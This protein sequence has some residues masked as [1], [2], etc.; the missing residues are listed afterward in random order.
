MKKVR[1]WVLLASFLSIFLLSCEIGLGAAVDTTAPVISISNPPVDAV[2]RDAFAFSGSYSDDGT[3]IAASITLSGVNVSGSYT[4]GGSLSG[5]T[6]SCTID[7]VAQSIPDGTYEASVM[8]MDYGGHTSTSSRSFTI[9][10]T[11]PIVF[12]QRPGSRTTADESEIDTYGQDFTI[13]G[14]VADD[15]SISQMCVSVYDDAAATNL[16]KTITIA[17]VPQS[18]NISAAKFG[19]SSYTTIYGDTVGDKLKRY[20]KIVCYDD[21][22]RYPIGSSQ[23]SEDKLGNAKSYFYLRDEVATSVLANFKV[24]DIYHMYSGTQTKDSNVMSILNDDSKKVSVGMFYLNPKNNPYFDVTGWT[25]YTSDTIKA[26]ISSENAKLVC[27]TNVIVEVKQGSDGIPLVNAPNLLTLWVS[28][29]DENGVELNS[30]DRKIIKSPNVTLSKSGTNYR[31][32][33]LFDSYC[34]FGQKYIVGVTGKDENGNEIASFGKIYGFTF[35]SS[36]AA[37]EVDI[38]APSDAIYYLKKETDLTVKGTIKVE[39]NTTVTVRIYTTDGTNPI[40]EDITYTPGLETPSGSNFETFALNTTIPYSKF[41]ANSQTPLRIMATGSGSTTVS[42]TIVYDT[43]GPN[44]TL[45]VT[46]AA[47]TY[48][49]N[50]DESNY[51]SVINSKY[52]NGII[53]LKGQIVD[54]F[55][56]V[57]TSAGYKPKYTI[58]Q[59]G[60]EKLSGTIDNPNSFNISIDTTSLT[61]DT[62][63]IIKIE[64]Y[65]RCLNKSVTTDA[66]YTYHV[67][68]STDKPVMF[69][70]DDWKLSYIT[71]TI[72]SEKIADAVNHNTTKYNVYMGGA[73]LSTRIYDDD[74]ISKVKVSIYSD[75]AEKNLAVATDNGVEKTVS[76]TP[77]D[78]IYIT[79]LPTVLGAYKVVYT[80]TDKNS[81]SITKRFW[82][83]IRGTAP[84][85]QLSAT[86]SSV[87][88]VAKNTADYTTTTAKNSFTVTLDMTGSTGP[89]TI[90]RGTTQLVTGHTEATYTDTFTPAANS[91]SSSVNYKVVDMFGGETTKVFSYVVDKT[92][93]TVEITA[94]PDA[95]SSENDTVTIVGTGTDGTGSGIAS[96]QVKFTDESSSLNSGNIDFSGTTSWNYPL[97]FANSLVFYNSGNLEGIKK[98]YVRAI[99]VNGNIGEWTSKEFTFDKSK[100]SISL[101]KYTPE[102]G[103]ATDVANGGEFNIGKKFT[104]S[105]TA[106]DTYGVA[107][108]SVKQTKDDGTP[109]ALTDNFG[110][111]LSVAN[112][113]R[114]PSSIAS[115]L[116]ETGT[117]KYDITVTDKAGK[118]TTTSVTTHIDITP[119]VLKITAPASLALADNSGINSLSGSSYTFAGTATDVGLGIQSVQYVFTE[120]EALSGSETWTTKSVNGNWNFSQTLV[121]GITDVT[122]NTLHEGK[123]YLHA[124]AVDKAN[125][126]SPVVTAGFYA[127]QSVPS[128]VQTGLNDSGIKYFNANVALSIT[129]TDTFGID[130]S[131]VT[132]KIGN[133]GITLARTSGTNVWTGTIAKSTLTKNTSYVVTITAKDKAGRTTEK[134]YNV[135]YDTAKPV[136]TIISPAASESVSTFPKQISGTSSDAGS[137]VRRAYY[138]LAATPSDDFTDGSW[139]EL[140][141]NGDSWIAKLLNTDPEAGD[142]TSSKI[143]EEGT[144][145]LTVSALDNLSNPKADYAQTTF[146][147]DTSNPTLSVNNPGTLT[148]AAFSITGTA[149][150][151]NNISKIEIKEG[152]NVI[153]STESLIDITAGTIADAKS[154]A[155]KFSWSKTFMVGAGKN[156]EDGEHTYTVI[157]TDV[158]GKTTERTVNITVD[159]TP[160]VVSSDIKVPTTTETESASFTFS[161]TTSDATS[162]V[163]S[164]EIAFSDP[165]ANPAPTFYTANGKDNWTYLAYFANIAGFDTEGVKNVYVRA[166]DSAGNVSTWVNKAYTYDKAAPTVTITKYNNTTIVDGK[167]QTKATFSLTGT[168]ADGYALAD[169]NN[170]VI[171]QKKDDGTPITLD[172]SSNYTFTS[173]TWTISGLPRK[174]AKDALTSS[175]NDAAWTGSYTYTVTAKDKVD[176]TNAATVVS[177]IDK[178]A[179]ETI[180]ISSPSTDVTAENSLFG[181]S[182]IFKGNASDSGTGVK[183]IH[184]IFSKS[185]TAPTDGYTTLTAGNGETWSISRDLTVGHTYDSATQLDEGNWCLYVKAE[186]YAGNISET[187]KRAFSV[188]QSNPVFS[189]TDTSAIIKKEAFTLSGIATDTN[190]LTKVTISNGK[191]GTDAKSWSSANSAISLNATTGA[192]SKTFTVGSSGDVVDGEYTFVIEATDAAGKTTKVNKSI[193]VDTVAPVITAKSFTWADDNAKTWHNKNNP[194][195][196]ITV[197][198]VN[199]DTV[200]YY[201]AAGS[202]PAI[203]EVPSADW[204]TVS[205]SSVNG[206]VHTFARSITI[207]DGSGKV[208]LKVVDTAG[209]TTTDDSL[210]YSVDTGNPVVLISAPTNNSL[211]NGGSA[212]TVS[213]TITDDGCKD[214]DKVEFYLNGYTGTA[215]AT[216]NKTDSPKTIVATANAGEFSFTGTFPKASIPDS[217]D[218]FKIYVKAY[219]IAGN[220]NYS[221]ANMIL[222]KVN[223]SVSITLPPSADTDRTGVYVNGKITITGTGS[224]NKTLNKVDLYYQSGVTDGNPVWTLLSTSTGSSAYNW[225]SGEI[226]TAASQS[227]FGTYGKDANTGVQ[228]VTLKA[229]ATDEAGNTAETTAT[230]YVDQDTDR[231]IIRFNNLDL[232]SSMTSSAP[233]LLKN[234]NIVYGTV[235]D[236][237]GISEFKYRIGDTGD[238]TAI[239]VSNGSWNQSFDDG[240]STI[241]FYVKDTEGK[242]FTSSAT[243]GPKLYDGTNKYGIT[244]K[245]D[246]RFFLKVDTANPV[247][248]D[249]QYDTFSKA[250]NDYVG[251]F[252]TDYSLGKFGG[253]TTKF[254]VTLKAKDANAIKSV[255]ATIGSNVYPGVCADASHDDAENHIW[256]I[257]DIDV[258]SLASGSYNCVITVT[259]GCALFSTA[260]MTIS[261]DNTEP[262]IEIIKPSTQIS[263]AEVIR[264]T[265]DSTATIYYAVSRV[266]NTEPGNAAVTNQSTA[267]AK[268]DYASLSWNVYFDGAEVTG[269]THTSL[270]RKYISELGI[271]T[272]ASITSGTYKDITKLYVWIKAVDECGNVSTKVQ[273]VSIDPQGNRPKLT[274]SYPDNDTILGGTVRIYGTVTDDLAGK[275]VW[276]QL[277][278]NEDGYYKA[279]DV[280]NLKGYG[281]TI[282]EITSGD[283]VSNVSGVTDD[284]AKNYAIKV[285]V[286]GVSWNQSVNA[287]GEFNPSDDGKK[288]VKMW[289]S[290]TDAEN[291]QS[292]VDERKMIIDKGSPIID[293]SKLNLVQYETSSGSGVA[294]IDGTVKS[295][296]IVASQAF[297]EV[298]SVKGVWFLTGTITDAS[299]IKKIVKDDITVVETAGGSTAEFT[300]DVNNNYTMNIPLGSSVSDS[301]GESSVHIVATENTDT[302]LWIEKTFS[303]KYDNKKPEIVTTEDDGLNI[304]ANITNSNGFYKLASVAKEKAVNN[305][306]QTGVER[307]AF[308]FTRDITA[309]TTHDL[310]D[311]MIKNGETG[312]AL[313]SYTTSLTKD[314]GLYWKTISI[315]KV[316]GDVITLSSDDDNVHIGG[317][318]KVNGVIYRITAKSGN[319]RTLSGQPGAATTA[320]FALA[321]VIDNTTTEGTGKNLNDAGYYTDSF[322]DDG[323]LMIESLNKQGTTYYWEAYINS[324]IFLMDL[325]M[326]IM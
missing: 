67:L 144:Y 99:D 43:A 283:T 25:A 8:L 9:D 71:K 111:T 35:A 96:Y 227:P 145:V 137:G 320:S 55:D 162:S 112:L 4:F 154:D 246:T 195:L 46:P 88:T 24:N 184:Y 118:T 42:K 230:L 27:G 258:H 79:N 7:P 135:Y 266:D 280:S 253:D 269:Q 80:V 53:Y 212:I 76:G 240:L 272:E 239:T 5:T 83:Q 255:T 164:V 93:P 217:G 47:S 277:D 318:A 260:T 109:V 234:T 216:L 300:P 186:D 143:T 115:Y 261:V 304:N 106:A 179:P 147:Y 267:W 89:F 64:A 152:V 306:D 66:D 78:T 149:W 189:S 317:L 31:F 297:T 251:I 254:K 238:F 205:Q 196:N 141:P 288:D 19:D 29:C 163:S 54:E 180:V 131:G 271:T 114:N 49:E 84:S 132:A 51:K 82:I 41:T 286:S 159:T 274:V 232:T 211:T 125:N 257:S 237:D 213:G 198:E 185:T 290:A 40:I 166:T 6:W 101:L 220:T 126:Y 28:Q 312:N 18:L 174:T 264:G 215:I 113:P 279:E 202:T 308:Y 23:T 153:A 146:Y 201:V 282:G 293:Q 119:P 70:N 262:V 81:N 69:P 319:T 241:Y 171:T 248:S 12:L 275:Y 74:G 21:A 259:D 60:V 13:Q 124:R 120:N 183:Q 250:T 221:Y 62:N 52:L 98:V 311:V 228:T 122:E 194:T 17:N 136:V 34:S 276:I 10:N 305:V 284:T 210:V 204:I 265:V 116:L 20:C 295:G 314:E 157:A 190:S 107:S 1:I 285:T 209:N 11:A 289:I 229:V 182:Y 45:N 224:D 222:D 38:T 245:V 278:T 197:T 85:V 200:S 193:T 90:Y 32:V 128:V 226:N 301:V 281:Y 299:G 59:G 175:D 36:G 30:N 291:N 252:R 155:T 94:W 117:Y 123:W 192:W 61:D 287:N 223:P 326:F 247:Y 48:Q 168:A 133:N 129:A 110:T 181:A 233:V 298:M 95:T 75:D 270:F 138:T 102:G 172:L 139:K 77:T 37:P 263:N 177:V 244:G 121:D 33:A 302:G 309:T 187:V 325:L 105:G 140:T 321:N 127:D 292:V 231:P 173:G 158:A 294:C 323:D 249:L 199:I 50:E 214:F 310:Y 104:L 273:A 307:I 242:E 73:S 130:D 225:T 150:D 324:K 148:K 91:D 170:I 26:G 3:V 303:V 57:N 191:T 313:S 14:Q 219:D 44:I 156:A 203:G 151:G 58:T 97:T 316:A 87:T 169:T 15:N 188:D 296:T 72:L 206:N 322:Y 16:I 256:T 86:P 218:S 103:S 176:K 243:A 160:P 161:G 167:F 235:T 2:V 108:I 134:T 207:N 268:E 92:R 22:Q 142:T 165:S 39:K 315:T 208:Y 65:D 68:Q 63:A 56:N 236:D 100:P 178:V